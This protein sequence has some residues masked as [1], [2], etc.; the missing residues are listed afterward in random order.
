MRVT[1][2]DDNAQIRA[3]LRTLVETETGARVVG[4]ADDGD[5]AAQAVLEAEADLVIV[6][7][8]M[9]RVDGIE[10]TRQILATCPTARVVAFTSADDE[11]V[12][13]GFLAAGAVRHFDKAQIDELI[14]FIRE[15]S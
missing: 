5:H 9:E 12:A 8:R 2:V 10:A 11:A 15:L 14:A 4:E 13:A 7:Y 6:D 3:L 1:I